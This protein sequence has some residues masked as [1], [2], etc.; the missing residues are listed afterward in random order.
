MTKA[1]NDKTI[2]APT[3]DPSKP[4]YIWKIM[5]EVNVSRRP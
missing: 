3:E 2:R 5:K 4:I 1:Y